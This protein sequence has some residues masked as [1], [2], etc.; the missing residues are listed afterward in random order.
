MDRHHG[1]LD[2]PL[3]HHTATSGVNF[4]TTHTNG[5]TTMGAKNP[6]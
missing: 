6:A 5:I 1:S 4:F 3:R 2:T